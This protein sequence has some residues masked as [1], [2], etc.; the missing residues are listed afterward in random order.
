VRSPTVGAPIGLAL[1]QRRACEPGTQLVLAT[2]EAAE[3][4]LPPFF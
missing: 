3:V 4:V 1:L 2:G